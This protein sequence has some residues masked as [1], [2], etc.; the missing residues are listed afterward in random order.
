MQSQYTHHDTN[1]SLKTGLK[2]IRRSTPSR[3]QNPPSETRDEVCNQTIN[4]ETDFTILAT[5]LKEI[6]LTNMSGSTKEYISQNSGITRNQE[7][8][9]VGNP[10]N[11]PPDQVNF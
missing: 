7:G 6:K 9:V 10:G 1:I 3:H 8:G 2:T 4:F 5:Q 11:L